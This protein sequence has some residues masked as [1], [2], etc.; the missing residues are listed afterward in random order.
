ML[1]DQCDTALQGITSTLREEGTD[2]PLIYFFA[3]GDEVLED[4]LTDKRYSSAED[5][6]DDSI[7]LNT[8]WIDN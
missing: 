1:P 5:L 3:N 6:E 2:D 4:S 8:R 7:M